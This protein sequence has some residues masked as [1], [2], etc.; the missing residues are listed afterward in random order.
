MQHDAAC[1]PDPEQHTPSHPDVFSPRETDFLVANNAQEL[2]ISPPAPA[3][4]EPIAP[5]PGIGEGAGRR[6]YLLAVPG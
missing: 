6:Q 5:S 1:A 2:N 3:S 4:S